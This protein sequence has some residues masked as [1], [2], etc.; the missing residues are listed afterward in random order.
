MIYADRVK[1]RLT[2]IF[3]HRAD[4]QAEYHFGKTVDVH[5]RTA[6]MLLLL[7]AQ[8]V[9]YLTTKSVE[10]VKGIYDIHDYVPYE[11]LRTETG[12]KTIDDLLA[13]HTANLDGILL[14][15]NPDGDV[16]FTAVHPVFSTPVMKARDILIGMDDSLAQFIRQGG[17]G[18][19]LTPKC[20]IV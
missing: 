18:R 1:Q 14:E 8:K 19:E 3:T 10:Q 12:R 4:W 13:E 5:T 9:N 20:E 15:L 2:Y 11:K 17:K 16:V 7:L 6:V